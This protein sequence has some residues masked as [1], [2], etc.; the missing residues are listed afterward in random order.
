MAKPVL[1]KCH[2]L[3]DTANTG[4]ISIPAITAWFDKTPLEVADAAGK[5]YTITQYNLTM[6]TMSPLQTRDFGVASDVVPLLAK[7]A[8][9]AIKPGDTIFLKEISAKD[10]AGQ[11]IKLANII[12]SA[13]E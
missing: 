13:G 10:S 2:I 5:V 1:L 7:K 4:K 6:I 12:F 11:E 9:A 8:L 3:G